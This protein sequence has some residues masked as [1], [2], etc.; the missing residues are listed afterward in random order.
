MLGEAMFLVEILEVEAINN[1]PKA[2][3]V[4]SKLMVLA[5]TPVR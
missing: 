1:V 3:D 2:F 4:P 5:S